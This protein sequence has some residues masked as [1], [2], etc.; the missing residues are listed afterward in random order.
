MR[1]GSQVMTCGFNWWEETMEH[2]VLVANDGREVFHLP[3]YRVQIV[4]VW[5]VAGTQASVLLL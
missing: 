1:L 4:V 5:K 3:A 2:M